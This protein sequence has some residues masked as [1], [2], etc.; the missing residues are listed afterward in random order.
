MFPGK[1]RVAVLDG[2][3]DPDADSIATFDAQVAGFEQAFDQFASD[4]VTHT[5]CSSLGDPRQAAYAVLAGAAAPP[6]DTGTSRPLTWALAELGILQ[7]LYSQDLWN[8]LANGLIQAQQGDGSG[9]LTLADDYS[10]RYP[11]GTY[12][13]LLDANTVIGC[14]DSDVN[15][16]DDQIRALTQKWVTNYPMFGKWSAISLFQC[17]NWPAK[18]A[19]PPKPTAPDSAPILV[20]GNTHDPATPYQGAINLTAALG[21]AELLT[22]DGQGHT[23]YMNGSKCIDD[24]VNAYLLKG[25]LPPPNTTC[26]A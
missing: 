17:Q 20:V 11:D 21:S 6:L 3:V 12:S 4:C 2:A 26:P 19:P 16:T 14:N 23:A 5:P 15:P 10:E 9:L 8:N 25:Q 13:N 1:V 7:A 18:T 22:W 24:Y